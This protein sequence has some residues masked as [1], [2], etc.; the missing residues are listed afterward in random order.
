[1]ANL[2]R[3]IFVSMI[4]V[5]SSAPAQADIYR[6]I[7][8]NG[9]VTYTNVPLKKKPGNAEYKLVLKSLIR[10]RKGARTSGK[11]RVSLSKRRARFAP[12]IS[13]AARVN[14]LDPE[15]IHAV[16]RAESSYNPK[17]VSHKGAVGLMQLMPQTAS[18]YGVKNR[19]D[20]EQ[21]IRG[22][23]R[24]LRDLIKL[25]ESDIRLA[26]A[27]YNAG[28]HN[29]I[30]YGNKIPPFKETRNYVARVMKYYNNNL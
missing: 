6:I 15:L 18:R 13:S 26:V 2:S 28:E 8:A 4:L 5:G 24:Y 23:A 14:S 10:P 30:K 19:K 21:N 3:L 11:K 7:D 20:P 29:V 16:I 27:A 9:K 17:A 22:G 1:M 25:F 12:I